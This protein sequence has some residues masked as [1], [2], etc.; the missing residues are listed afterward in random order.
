M[1]CGLG[2]GDRM[3]LKGDETA[4]INVVDH[5]GGRHA[6]DPRPQP[7]ADRLDTVVVP[8]ARAES[9]ARRLVTTQRIEPLPALLVVQPRTPAARRRVD[10]GLIPVHHAVT[11]IRSALTAD[12][13][14]RIECRIGLRIEFDDEVAILRLGYEP[15][16][17]LARF[18]APD[19]L[20]ILEG[21]A[22]LAARRAPAGQPFARRHIAPRRLCL[23]SGGLLHRCSLGPGIDRCLRHQRHGRQGQNC[24]RSSHSPPLFSFLR[25]RVGQPSPDRSGRLASFTA[26][27]SLSYGLS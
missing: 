13:H 8:V 21:I 10:L 27:I 12:H 23:V 17:G 20:A 26:D 3:D 15:A 4:C 11:V 14:A 7:R 9:L 1:S 18:G 5:I 2:I 19:H 25:A 16:I 22:R 24:E 6:V